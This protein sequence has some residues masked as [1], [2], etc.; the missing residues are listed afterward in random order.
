LARL[1]SERIA[2]TFELPATDTEVV[3][4]ISRIGSA[5][6]A[7][8][9]AALSMLAIG[10]GSAPAAHADFDICTIAPMTTP[11]C[12]G[13]IDP[14][15]IVPHVGCPGFV[16]TGLPFPKMASLQVMP[17]AQGRVTSPA[18]TG[19]IPSTGID[20][21]SVGMPACIVM[22]MYT[23][24]AGPTSCDAVA[25]TV[26]LTAS[27]G[28]AGKVPKWSSNCPA[29]SANTCG[30]KMV[31]GLQVTLTWVDPPPAD[32]TTHT[33]APVTPQNQ[34]PQQQETPKPKLMCKVPKLKGK[35]LSAAR[36]ILKRA[37]CAVGKVK[38]K[39]A[40]GKPGRV[41]AQGVPAGWTRP[42]GAKVA[43]TVSS[44]R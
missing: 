2:L 6:L 19:P 29:Q 44:R 42:N 12:P 17:P 41:I 27:E 18:I 14:T 4:S 25:P 36:K 31:D 8:A 13:Y 43:L 35:T 32:D 24:P 20:C 10:L 37:N 15:C 38:K 3:L 7:F 39:K 9:A 33:P 34:Q 11:G 16:D 26:T 23:C 21:N 1:R 22:V 28:P 30:A 5:L 40:A